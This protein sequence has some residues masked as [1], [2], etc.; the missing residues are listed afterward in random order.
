MD[1]SIGARMRR[2]TPNLF[3]YPHQLSYIELI[4]T[5]LWEIQT[6]S[7]QLSAVH[8]LGQSRANAVLRGTRD[9]LVLRSSLG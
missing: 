7:G 5:Y 3:Q 6:P 1:G 4:R 8:D 2:A 9:V